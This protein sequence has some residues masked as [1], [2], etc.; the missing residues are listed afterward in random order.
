MTMRL[1]PVIV[2]TSRECY[3]NQHV[4]KTFD[5][6][7]IPFTPVLGNVA[8]TTGC[9]L[10]IAR[11]CSSDGNFAVLA[12]GTSSSW[13]LQF[14]VPGHDIRWTWREALSITVN[15]EEKN[16]GSSQPIVV[17][18]EPGDVRCAEQFDIKL[19]AEHNLTRQVAQLWQRDRASSINDFR[20]GVNLRL[21]Y[22]LKG[23]FLRHCDMTQF[24]LTHHMVNKPFLLFGLAAKY[25]SMTV[26]VINVAADLQ[27]FETLTGELR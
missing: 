11:D 27:M 2:E 9:E 3:M 21:N 18:K 14:L 6:L 13:G 26:A 25:R 5:G 12:S 20:W 10:L 23:Y 15:G 19:C 4:V 8:A 17:R 24:T 1:L 7:T 16:V 22:R